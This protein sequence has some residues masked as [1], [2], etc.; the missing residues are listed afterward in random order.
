MFYK[1]GYT[2]LRGKFDY[3]S[4]SSQN[5]KDIKKFSFFIMSDHFG[6]K[7]YYL[8]NLFPRLLNKRS[9]TAKLNW[10]IWRKDYPGNWKIK[11]K[12]S[13]IGRAKKNAIP[14]TQKKISMISKHSLW[15]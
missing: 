2:D 3:A 5:I 11:S 15:K 6:T 13:A 9:L 1:D 7:H 12:S 10:Q 14:G 8:S 4:A